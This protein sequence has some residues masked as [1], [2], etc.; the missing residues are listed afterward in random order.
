MPR[1]RLLPRRQSVS[2]SGL[3]RVAG[4]R[5]GDRT[6]GH[7]HGSQTKAVKMA[8]EWHEIYA[9][10]HGDK[11]KLIGE[12]TEDDPHP[13]IMARL[14][15]LTHD[16]FADRHLFWF[17]HGQP[18][19]RHLDDEQRILAREG[20]RRLHVVHDAARCR[21]ALWCLYSIRLRL[22]WQRELHIHGLC[23]AVLPP[24]SDSWFPFKVLR[25]CRDRDLL[26]FGRTHSS[27]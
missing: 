9:Q 25:V 4:P 2:R 8:K 5:L 20:A 18:I 14:N 27:P 12:P 10:T 7:Q 1:G 15:S 23:T 13:C 16:E 11:I 26:P 6:C 22:L 24:S 19:G 21:P 17:V 3:C